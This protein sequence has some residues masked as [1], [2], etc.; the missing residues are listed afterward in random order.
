MKKII[1]NVTHSIGRTKN[2]YVKPTEGE[3]FLFDQ[4]KWEKRIEKSIEDI[5]SCRDERVPNRTP[6][7]GFDAAWDAMLSYASPKEKWMVN[8]L[9]E[10]AFED[11]D[12]AKAPFRKY[13]F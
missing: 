1:A 11:I 7:C 3:S 5:V 2:F 6:T 8:Q 4:M 9:V 13:E 12:W 10:R